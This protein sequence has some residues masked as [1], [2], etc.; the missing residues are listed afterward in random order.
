V[1]IPDSSLMLPVLRL[2]RDRQEDSLADD[3]VTITLQ[4]AALARETPGHSV[5]WLPDSGS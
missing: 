3:A 4:T 1:P 5:T 2:V